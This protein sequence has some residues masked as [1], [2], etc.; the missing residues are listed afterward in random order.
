MSGAGFSSYEGQEAE[1]GKQ[2]PVLLKQPTAARQTPLLAPVS[3]LLSI[4]A[5]RPGEH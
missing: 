3:D 1:S 4:A 2:H 5:P